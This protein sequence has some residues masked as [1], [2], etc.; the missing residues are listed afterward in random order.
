MARGRGDGG[1]PGEDP[2]V[3]SQ[4]NR[5]LP[6][7]PLAQ[8]QPGGRCGSSRTQEVWGQT[9]TLPG[10]GAVT[11]V[12]PAWNPFPTLSPP[13]QLR[14]LTQDASLS[15]LPTTPAPLEVS[16]GLPAPTCAPVLAPVTLDSASGGGGGGEEDMC[17]NTGA[18]PR[19]SLRGEASATVC[20]AAS[21]PGWGRPCAA[22][23]SPPISPWRKAQR[24]DP[25][26][27]Q[28]LTGELQPNLLRPMS[29]GCYL[30]RRL[31]ILLPIA[32]SIRTNPNT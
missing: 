19:S 27:S 20:R 22:V 32:K 9:P 13:G 7:S 16:A 11:R 31:E 23:T 24:T 10:L 2:A 29:Q 6:G 18:L 1:D 17:A 4:P 26:P 28:S 8:G 14:F 12:L 30:F 25:H 15:S 3:S 21:L 5:T